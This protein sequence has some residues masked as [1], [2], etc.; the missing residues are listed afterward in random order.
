MWYIGIQKCS[1]VGSIC[2]G[3][4]D[5]AF[6]GISP[7]DGLTLHIQCYTI[8]PAQGSIDQSLTPRAIQISSLYFWIN[9]PV[10]PVYFSVKLTKHDILVFEG[11]F[12]MLCKKKANQNELNQLLTFSA[13]KFRHSV[14]ILNLYTCTRKII[15]LV[16]FRGSSTHFWGMHDATSWI[17]LNLSKCKTHMYFGVPVLMF[18]GNF[19]SQKP[20]KA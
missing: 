17:V 12:K 11:L 10:T 15:T 5:T 13:S 14:W 18:T 20:Y 1:S 3:S 8:R 16:E 6:L 7:V 19:F 9:S 2:V 4:L